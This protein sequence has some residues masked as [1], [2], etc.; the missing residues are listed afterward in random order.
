MAT[1]GS[2]PRVVITG[3]STINPLGD[4]LDGFADNLLAG[5]SGIRRWES[6]DV[7][8]IECKIGGDIGNYD[9]KKALAKYEH[10]LPEERYKIIRKL[11]KTATFSSKTAVL[12]AL[13]AFE[14]SHLFETDVDLFRM[15]APVGGHNLNS[16]YLFDNGAQ[17]REEPEFIE[18]LSGIEGIDPAIP[19][20]VTE[21][22]GL[23]G[24]AFTIGGACSSGNLAI[25][26]GFRD[27][28]T[29]ECERS[30]VTGALFDMCTADL[31]ASE[32]I[33][34]IV[35]RPDL[36]EDP[37]RASR[38]FDL[39]RGGF[40]YSHGCGALVL[41]NREL[42]LARGARIYAE[43]LGVQANA[44]GNHLPVPS[45][46]Y[47]HLLIKQ[48]LERTGVAPE[49]IDYV[50]CHA[51]STPA[52]DIQ[53]I[54][55]I[56]KAL[57]PHAYDVRLN[58][59]KSMLGHTCWAAPIVETI[60]GILQMERGRLH[61]SINIDELDP[62]IDLDVCADGP[63]EVDAKLML[64]NSFGFGGLNCCTLIRKYEAGE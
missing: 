1:N 8:N 50:N 34:A 15:S 38:P 4:S 44:N 55:A 25:R 2:S 7:S 60:G 54:R 31:H 17:F 61:Q 9:C 49:E 11:F 63:V 58:A 16:K 28:V 42:A 13:G 14:D 19:G 12:C 40:I 29:G 36:L 64:K 46:E 48:L 51:T 3:M 57:G 52:G 62:E 22:L 45:A 5:V 35:V 53:E 23:H 39:N 24:P 21:A 59:P 18:P 56:K 41:E 37:T 30:L 32:F 33:N 20:L 26:E 27:I 6:L 10:I 43:I 47:Q